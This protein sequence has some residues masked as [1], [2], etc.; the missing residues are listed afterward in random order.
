MCWVMLE[1]SSICITYSNQDR[2]SNR[3]NGVYVLILQGQNTCSSSHLAPLILLYVNWLIKVCV[4]SMY[5]PGIKQ[6][7][8]VVNFFLHLECI[9]VG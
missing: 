3:E 2:A 8:F 1:L 7:S 4:S 5:F 9:K 6:R